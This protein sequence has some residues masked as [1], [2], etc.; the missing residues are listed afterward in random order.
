[1]NDAKSTDWADRRRG[2]DRPWLSAREWLAFYCDENGDAEMA[3]KFLEDDDDPIVIAAVKASISFCRQEI[4]RGRGKA[5][6]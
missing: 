1:M 3:R 5:D 2:Y 6:A 4:Q